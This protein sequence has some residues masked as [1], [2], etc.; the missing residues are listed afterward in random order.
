VIVVTA[1]IVTLRALFQNV[2]LYIEHAVS[3]WH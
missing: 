3:N 1:E 2:P